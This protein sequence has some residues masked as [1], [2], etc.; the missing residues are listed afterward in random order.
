MISSTYVPD[1]GPKGAKI[2]IV[3][4]APGADEETQK[5]PFVGKSGELLTQALSRC[6]INR[7]QVRLANLCH[8]RPPNNKFE[9]LLKSEQLFSGIQELNNY[10][11]EYKPNVIAALGNWPLY[12]LTSKT[13][14]KK[15]K[16]SGI[17][18]YRGSILPLK[19]LVNPTL[20]GKVIPTYHP[21][22]VLRNH[23]NYPIF[24]NDISRIVEDST[25][26]ELNYPEFDIQV[27]YEPS[28]D[29]LSE[30]L[31]AP[32][33]GC[34]IESVR[35]ST[36]IL[37]I[38]FAVSP[39][40]VYVYPWNNSTL[41]HIEKILSSPQPKVFHNGLFD[42]TVLLDNGVN[43]NNYCEDTMLLQ[44]VMWPEL[45]RALSYLTSVYTRMPYYKTEGRQEIPDRKSWS[46]KT[47]RQL[48]YEY[49]GK[50]G[51]VTLECYLKMKTE[52]DKLP[53][54][55]KDTYEFEIS[56]IPFAIDV[57][58]TGMLR[59]EQVRSY[60][61]VA[62]Y[63]KWFKMQSEL[64]AY[65]GYKLNVRSTPAMRKFL[66]EK[67]K[68]PKKFDRATH[69]LK[70]DEDTI[71]AHIAYCKDYADGLKSQALKKTWED[72]YKALRLILNIRGVRQMLA[73]FIMSRCSDDGRV[74]AGY[75]IANTETGRWAGSKYVD[76][77]GVNPQTYPRD[78]VDVPD[79]IINAVDEALNN[80]ML[81]DV[82]LEDFEGEVDEGED[83][84]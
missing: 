39:T 27:V 63:T 65:C 26:P 23:S 55:Y 44:H 45:P 64:D 6:G 37:C 38:C 51:C 30:I 7:D 22:F 17:S 70:C 16:A 56:E 9:A 4:E 66:Y 80:I 78:H 8:Y 2:L 76:D 28:I 61:K 48:L 83:E 62:L 52:L 5:R 41:Q 47:N 14:L 73:S 53:R 13:S 54:H 18:N 68:L 3:G 15:E 43:V 24:I 79:D 34:D 71:V 1:E 20:T 46:D 75:K 29:I 42:A 21:A 25:F 67:L 33:L 58:R 50:D 36:H 12:F 82:N 72:R 10:I 19:M 40:K 49:N 31:E 77:T 57:G 69:N 35:K 32:V 11:T 60:L 84:E 74:R 59:S 81:E